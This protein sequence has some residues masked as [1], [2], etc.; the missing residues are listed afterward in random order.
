[1]AGKLLKTIFCL[2]SS[3][4]PSATCKKFRWPVKIVKL[5]NDEKSKKLKPINN[6]SC[7]L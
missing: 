6:F 1:M 7:N 5:E 2:R 3:C 4:N